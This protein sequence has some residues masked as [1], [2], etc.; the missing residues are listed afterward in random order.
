[1]PIFPCHRKISEHLLLPLP[2]LRLR[3]NVS[4]VFLYVRVG[5][6]LETL[7]KSSPSNLFPQPFPGFLWNEA[8]LTFAFN[9]L[10]KFLKRGNSEPDWDSLN[11]ALL[12]S[13]VQRAPPIFVFSQEHVFIQKVLGD[14]FKAV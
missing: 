12:K 7:F 11:V 10:Q 1:M 13:F 3:D 14:V 6:F 8:F 5:L 9:S 2:N 4:G